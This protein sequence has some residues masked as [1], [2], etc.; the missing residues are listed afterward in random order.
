MLFSGTDHEIIEEL[1]LLKT[2][3]QKNI[4]QFIDS[5]IHSG[6]MYITE[7][8]M[9]NGALTDVLEVFDVIALPEDSIALICR[10]VL[11]ALKYLHSHVHVSHNDIKSDNILFDE[12]GRVK[13]TAPEKVQDT[14][15][16]DIWAL[17]TGSVHY[18]H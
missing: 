17:G 6:K 9:S 5:H 18:W 13:L 10:S 15:A 4:V 2:L 8:L 1:K 3:K 7:E 16:S 12:R 11:K 14:F